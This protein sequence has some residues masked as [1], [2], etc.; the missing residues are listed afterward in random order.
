MLALLEAEVPPLVV[1]GL[2]LLVLVISLA[3]VMLVGLG[4]PHS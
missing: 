4:R 2:A 1:G 3:Y